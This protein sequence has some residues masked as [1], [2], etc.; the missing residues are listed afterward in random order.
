VNTCN[1]ALLLLTSLCFPFLPFP[2]LLYVHT[3]PIIILKAGTSEA[4]TRAALSH[5]G[6]LAGNNA[7]F[8][9]A[10]QRAGCI[11]VERISQLFNCA[12]ALGMQPRP[13]RG[14]RLAI[15]TNAGG[16]GVLC[17]DRVTARGG[18]LARLSPEMIVQIDRTI[19][20]SDDDDN[21][22][23]SPVYWSRSNPIDVLEDATPKRY[24]AVLDACISCEDVDGIAV[25]LTVQGLTDA[26]GTARELV[27]VSKKQLHS[28][29]QK[30]ILACFMGESDVYE[31]T[32]VLEQ[33]KIPNFAFPESAVDV[34]MYTY[35]YTRNLE[36]LYETPPEAPSTFHRNRDKAWH[37]IR[38][39]LVKGRKCLL[40]HEAK[41]LLSCYDLPVSAFKVATDEKQ[42]WQYAMELGFPLVM[43]VLSADVAHKSDVGGVYLN[44]ASGAE[45]ERVFK[46]IMAKKLAS[47]ANAPTY[48]I[49][50]VLMEKMHHKRYE[51]L[52][53]ATK[54]PIFGPLL[55]FGQ[56]GAAVEVIRDTNMGLPPLN[57]AL[58]KRIIQNTQI[59]K[60]LK[61]FRSIPSV[62][63]NDLAFQLQ[64]FSQIVMD[65]PEIEEI[66]V[67]PYLVDETGG[68][69]ADAHMVLGSYQRKERGH[70]YQHLV[71]S[72][73]PEKY[74]KTIKAANGQDVVLRAIRPEDEP[75][76]SDML[77]YSLSAKSLSLRFMGCKPTLTHTLLT[78]FTQI[79]YDREMAIV[80]VIEQADG[81]QKMIG[82][83]R[84]IADAWVEA[85]EFA[86]VVADDWHGEGT[87]FVHFG[88]RKRERERDP[89]RFFLNGT[90]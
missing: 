89:S 20:E 8:E 78:R 34:F 13:K 30:P 53:G 68:V 69:I 12:H 15:V 3:Q 62:D 16:P 27:E 29:H 51:L 67:N 6:T 73:Y 79:D 52:F 77:S 37:I 32:R 47:V 48:T 54:D 87:S 81:R 40:E 42:V 36:F 1:P 64:K 33:G 7:A 18:Q 21:E 70:P 41:S 26:V 74:T 76:E 72:P 57:M 11:R 31:A 46:E 25:I 39:A 43:K 86:I 4:G 80:A 19:R 22:K 60:Q 61:G 58:A 59:Y 45:A 24:R 28:L 2:S 49:D 56:G 5:T 88:F 35:Q 17:T 9:A 38:T 14:S 75:I 71:I 84:I 23:K 63:L 44:I 10:F 82:V 50:G 66:D 90:L 83:A 65:F 85:A 55:V